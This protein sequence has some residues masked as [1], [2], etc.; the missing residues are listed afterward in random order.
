MFPIFMFVRLTIESCF[1]LQSY[2][3]RSF[4]TIYLVRKGKY[5]YRTAYIVV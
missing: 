5:D 3:L 2:Y 1:L 4:I